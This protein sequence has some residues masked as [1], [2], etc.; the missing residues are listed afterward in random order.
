MRAD[1]LAAIKRGQADEAKLIRML[2]AALDNA[3]APPLPA[4]KDH[5]GQ[6]RFSEG[7][8]EIER[9][10]LSREQ[11]RAILAGEID[12]REHMASEM[13]RHGRPDRADTLR[14]E[15]AIARRYID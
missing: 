7:T 6:S 14:A 9:L 13:V 2:I 15:A 12:E 11:V 3:E 8:A 10:R 4:G 1:L 5:A